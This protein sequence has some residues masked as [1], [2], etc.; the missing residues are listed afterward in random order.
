MSKLDHNSLEFTQALAQ[1]S[2]ELG[3][4]EYYQPCVR[5]LF[6]MPMQQWPMCC[7]GSCEPC[8]QTLVTVASR[9]CELLNIDPDR[10]PL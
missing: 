5:P 2:S 7:G 6:A 3:M 8:S 10:L 4:P 9:V 1:A